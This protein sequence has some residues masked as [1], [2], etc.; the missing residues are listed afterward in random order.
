M[1]TN[2]S[3]TYR[4]T[5][6]VTIAWSETTSEPA[7]SSPTHRAD[8]DHPDAFIDQRRGGRIESLDA[9]DYLRYLADDGPA[10][11]I[12]VNHHLVFSYERG[13]LADVASALREAGAGCAVA[14]ASVRHANS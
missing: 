7:W 1:T 8:F 10:V 4:V 2:L 11:R 5:F 6:P 14:P 12:W 3:A 13:W 9:P